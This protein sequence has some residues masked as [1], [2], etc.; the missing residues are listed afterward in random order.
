MFGALDR[1]RHIIAPSPAKAD[2]RS[3]ELAVDQ[4]LDQRY[5]ILAPLGAGGQSAVHLARDEAL[6]RE[7]A[8]KILDPEAAR[9]EAL[10]GRFVKEA[11]AL[12]ALSHP[13]IVAV[14]DVGEVDGLPFIVMEHLPGSL[15]SVIARE[16]PLEV[17]EAIRLATEIAAGLTAAHARGIVHA[18][19]KPSNIL[20]DPNGRAKIADFG[21]ARTPQDTG[22][23][24]QPFA[25]AQYVAPERVEGRPATQA[26]DIYGLGL[27]LYEMLVGHPPF[28]STDP[29]VLLRDHALRMPA[30]PS[31][32]RPALPK[33]LDTI[34]LRALAKTPALRYAR[35]ADLAEALGNLEGV[36]HPLESVRVPRDATITLQDLRAPQGERVL[37]ALI[38]RYAWPI[39]RVL[40]TALLLLPAWALLELV[41]VPR[42]YSVLVVGLPAIVALA[43]HLGMAVVLT[44]IVIS[45]LLLLFVPVLA[46]I[47]AVLGLWMATRGQAAEQT[48]IVL[49]LPV[50]APFGLAP[51]LIFTAT[52]LHGLAGVVA[53]IWGSIM[54]LVLAVGL[55]RP[56]LGPY[57][58]TGLPFE[59]PDLF[60]R[61]RALETL[62][63]FGDLFRPV[64]AEERTAA[65]I[66]VFDA[67]F[68]LNQGLAILS[69]IAAAEPTTLIG[70]VGAWALAA[71]TVWAIT[72]LMR[73]TAGGLFGPGRLFSLYLAGSAL[74][75]VAGAFVFY[76]LYVSWSPLADAPQRVGEGALFATALSGVVLAILAAAI[77]GPTRPPA[78]Q[79]DAMLDEAE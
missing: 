13:H 5:R 17:G 74:G 16:G 26:T 55:G 4:L 33:E 79:L 39:R 71:A 27:V 10:R 60:S 21:I 63:A 20:L 67:E 59:Q 24:P 31:Q 9:D 6:G 35:P 34:V 70:V 45:A 40:Y 49:A 7:V 12:A 75:A 37:V 28:T 65:L 3:V 69:R 51:A 41:G 11:R 53:A 72:R 29:T 44:W 2:R 62:A 46:V 38:A 58:L 73:M 47:F 57:V 56:T 36:A 25:T 76:A 1:S 78:S 68:L 42:P 23:A 19:L 32:L 52:A 54:T 48:A 64:P 61:A 43:G 66:A 8:L 50:V 77:I 18:D 14:F 15:K 30:P 22:D